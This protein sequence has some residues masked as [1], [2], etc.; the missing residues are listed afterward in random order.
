[1]RTPATLFVREFP[2]KASVLE[3]S[4]GY[5]CARYSADQFVFAFAP[6]FIILQPFTPKT[7]VLIVVISELYNES[8]RT[9]A[10]CTAAG[11]TA[12]SRRSR[13]L[14][15]SQV[16]GAATICELILK[17]RSYCVRIFFAGN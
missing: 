7:H 9:F 1:M 12:W 11:P 2:R 17:V 16:P 3:I 14:F 10:G 5:T 6:E 15:S 13:S 8:E 4:A